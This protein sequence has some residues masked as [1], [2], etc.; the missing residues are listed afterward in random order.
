VVRVASAPPLPFVLVVV[1]SVV[2]GV[3]EDLVVLVVLVRCVPLFAGSSLETETVFVPEDPH[4][5]VANTTA[6]VASSSGRCLLAL[7]LPPIRRK[8]LPSSH[9]SARCA[10]AQPVR[11][12]RIE[13]RS[14]YPAGPREARHP[15]LAWAYPLSREIFP[16][17]Y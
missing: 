12:E 11:E 9:W 2:V 6:A 3:G 8:K 16:K 17:Y 5:P 15:G 4:P 1:V 10:L 14:G 7:M 13:H